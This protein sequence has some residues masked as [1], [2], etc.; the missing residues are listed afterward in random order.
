MRQILLSHSWKVV[1]IVCV[2]LAAF[3]AVNAQ[4]G[5]KPNSYAPVVI[6]EDFATIMARMS[7]A[8]PVVMQRQLDLLNIRYDLSDTPAQ[9][10]T[11]SGG[12]PIQEGV[13]VLL[14]EG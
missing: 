12:K 1:M 14:P 3:G 13:R 2:L 9:G 5:K 8:K 6:P 10:I 7:E 11:M 4:E